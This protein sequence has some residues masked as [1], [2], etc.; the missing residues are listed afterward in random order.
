MPACPQNCAPSARAHGRG[1]RTLTV[2]SSPPRPDHAL[3]ALR[4]CGG[5]G[6]PLH[7]VPFTN[8][9]RPCAEKRRHELH[10]MVGRAVVRRVH[11]ERAAVATRRPE[12]VVSEL[13]TLCCCGKGMARELLL[14]DHVHVD[15]LGALGVHLAPR[16]VQ[17]RRPTE[18]ATHE[19]RHASVQLRAKRV[20]RG[21]AI[22]AARVN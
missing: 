19:V 9:L 14:A 4:V 12:I 15:P 5:R 10:R 18:G 11:R 16:P 17:R 7:R 6:C 2:G 1:H 8:C 13:A 21:H 20:C 3:E 22:P